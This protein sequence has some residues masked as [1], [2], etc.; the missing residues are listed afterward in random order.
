MVFLLVIVKK[1]TVAFFSFEIDVA[2]EAEIQRQKELIGEMPFKRI[3]EKIKDKQKQQ[4][5]NNS[6]EN[7]M[8]EK[9]NRKF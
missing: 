7:L 4:S 1:Y 8:K 6:D 5:R 3:V 9:E 2:K